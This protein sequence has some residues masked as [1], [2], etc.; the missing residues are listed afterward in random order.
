MRTLLFAVGLVSAS[1]D[2]LHR[3]PLKRVQEQPDHV[4]MAI[5]EHLEEV[6][7]GTKKLGEGMPEIGSSPVTIHDFGNAQYFGPVSVGSPLQEFQVIFDTGSSNLWIPSKECSSLYCK[8]HTLYDHS[9]STSYVADGTKFAIQY[10]SGPVAGYLS[11]DTVTLAGLELDQQRFAEINDVSGLG[12]AYL[13]GQFD[14][15]LGLGFDKLA[16]YGIPPT[17]AELVRLKKVDQAVFSFS[18]GVENG[19]DGE[20]LLG[21]VDEAKFDKDTLKY[22]PVSRAAYWQV[23]VPSIAVQTGTDQPLTYNATQA[24]VDSGTSAIVGPK[25]DVDALA[26]KL[27]AWHILGRVLVRT[28]HKFTVSWTIGDETYTLDETALVMPMKFGFGMLMVMG[29]DIPPPAGPLWILGD[30]FMRKYYSVFDYGGQRVGLATAVQSA[31]KKQ[32]YV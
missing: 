27:N 8:K 17:F 14:G 12:M 30:I 11:K 23:A 24:I 16:Q 32:I 21:G 2:K 28:S 5:L 6:E 1:G 3:V 31:E 15:I 13:A 22:Y 29:M 7:Q 20:L 26:K 18:L 9:K 10:G 25:A 4:R 19:Q